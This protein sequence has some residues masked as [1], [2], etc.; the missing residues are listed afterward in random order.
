MPVPAI[1]ILFPFHSKAKHLRCAPPPE[2]PPNFE[3]SATSHSHRELSSP[4]LESTPKPKSA[5]GGATVAPE[6]LLK[7][8]LKD[9]HSIWSLRKHADACVSARVALDD[10]DQ[11]K[12]V[13]R[14]AQS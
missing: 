6:K 8:K 14:T 7:I 5:S 9:L 1:S 2:P 12:E 13:R 3:H 10:S 11:N 4:K